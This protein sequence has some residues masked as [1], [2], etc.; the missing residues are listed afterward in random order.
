MSLETKL[1]VIDELF[2][3]FQESGF[4]EY[5]GEKVSQLEHAL[6]AAKLAE[7]ENFDDEVILAALFHDIGHLM[8]IQ[9]DDEKMGIF[10][11]KDH[12]QIGAHYLLENG[13]SQKI[14]ELIKGHVRTK[15]YLAYKN[16][17]YKSTLSE[18]SLKTLDYQGGPMTKVEAENFEKD[19]FFHLHLKMR[20]WDDKAKIPGLKTKSISEYKSKALEQLI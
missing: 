13:F 8:K 17:L 14:V 3:F 4:E 1:N 11:V 18:A 20:E 7:E 10:G 6:Q 5:A 19:D 2:N 15:K 9:N 16:P 12:E